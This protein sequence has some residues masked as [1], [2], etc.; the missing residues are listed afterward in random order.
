MLSS[1]TGKI[2]QQSL[3]R[4][5]DICGSFAQIVVVD[6]CDRLEVSL[7]DQP[8]GVFGDIF[9]LANLSFDLLNDCRIFENQPVHVEDRPFLFGNKAAHSMLDNI[10][11][12][13]SSFD[14][15][16]EPLHLALGISSFFPL[17][18]ADFHTWFKDVGAAS[19]KTW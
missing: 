5:F 4:V 15:R 10:Y 13:N 18:S 6:L 11:L 19:P 16:A 3:C 7:E 17:D 1:C 2:L 14:C 9:F 12:L 8:D